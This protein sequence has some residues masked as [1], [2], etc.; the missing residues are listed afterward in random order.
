MEGTDWQGNTAGGDCIALPRERLP[1]LRATG[2]RTTG[3]SGWLE[4]TRSLCG[5]LRVRLSASGRCAA[6]SPGPWG[7][8]GP[9][10][11]HPENHRVRSVCQSEPPEAGQDVR[12]PRHDALLRTD[13]ERQVQG[14]SQTVSQTG[15]LRRIKEALRMRWHDNRH[16]TA[17]WLGRVING[18]LSYYAVPGSSQSLQGF[19]HQCK[20]LLM[21]ALRRRSQKDFTGDIDTLAAAHWPKASIRGQ[22][23]ALSSGE[24]PDANSACPVLC[25]G[26]G[27]TR[28]P[29]AMCARQTGGMWPGASPERG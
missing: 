18:W 16:E 12:L 7:E 21:R 3:A 28:F 25:G 10:E 27:A 8:A 20:R 17:K 1:A 9:L 4:A 14:R 15:T 29:T 24:E 11:L 26:T 5:R 13:E 23:S 2:S 6:L 19:I 22:T